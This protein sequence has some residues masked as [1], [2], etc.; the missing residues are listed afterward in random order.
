M[1]EDLVVYF[2]YEKEISFEFTKSATILYVNPIIYIVPKILLG[3]IHI[4]VS[5][6]TENI[7]RKYKSYKQK[8]I[9]FLNFIQYHLL[10]LH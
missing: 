8:R 5:V 7:V 6:T 4:K 3:N 2:V 1:K 10:H 9:L